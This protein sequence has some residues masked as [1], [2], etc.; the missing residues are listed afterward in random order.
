M[1]G[2]I[3]RSVRAYPI[4]F[5]PR[6][7]L[8]GEVYAF[9]AEPLPGDYHPSCLALVD[10]H[11]SFVIEQIELGTSKQLTGD[12]AGH[13]FRLEQELAL[14]FGVLRKGQILRLTVRCE[15][16]ATFRAVMTGALAE[17]GDVP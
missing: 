1:T 4:A 15:A 12:I 5:G 14:T 11:D 8:T 13:T 3:P 7:M 17:M 2:N 16:G 10:K 9:E 6:P